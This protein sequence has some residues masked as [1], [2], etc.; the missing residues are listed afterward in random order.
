MKILLGVP[1]YSGL[2]PSVIVQSIFHLKK[3]CPVGFMTVD[4][5]PIVEARNIIARQALAEKYDYLLFMDDDNPIPRDTLVKFVEDDKDMVCAP[6]LHRNPDENGNRS[7]C[8]FYQ[9][10]QGDIRLYKPIERFPDGYLHKIAACGMGCTMIKREVLEAVDKKYPGRPF[11]AG[12]LISYN[13]G[14][15]II[16]AAKGLKRTMSEDLEFSERAGDAGFEIWCDTR[17]RPLHLTGFSSV[18]WQ[19]D[20]NT[21]SYWDEV[22]AREGKDTWRKYPLTFQKIKEQV[23][24]TV[25]DVGCGVGVLLDVLRESDVTGLDISPK[26]IEILKSKGIKGKVG[27]LP[28]IDFPDKSFDTVIATETLEHLDKPE[29]LIKEMRRVARKK[30]IVAVPDNVLGADEEKEHRQKFTEDTLR[31]LLPDSKIESFRDEFDNISLP[32]LLAVCEMEVTND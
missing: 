5:L 7:L 15:R 14:D 12:N 1:T 32:T 27:T 23:E 29:S 19:P 30:I 31:A 21:S 3:P 13:E 2:F 25:L 6:I 24:G 8:V 18:Q 28:T 10:L 22:W 4:R 17:I 16:D 26:A 20:V 9:Y 11:Q